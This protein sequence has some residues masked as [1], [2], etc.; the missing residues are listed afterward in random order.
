MLKVSLNFR[1]LIIIHEESIY[2]FRPTSNI[3]TWSEFQYVSMDTSL[4]Q[5]YE[6]SYYI[7]C[8][9]YSQNWRYCHRADIYKK[10]L[11]FLFLSE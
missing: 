10:R 5:Q 2:A 7:F 6:N 1:E 3:S 9:K 11:F 8:R 4:D